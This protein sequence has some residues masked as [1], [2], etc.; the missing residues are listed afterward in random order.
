[1]ATWFTAVAPILPELIRMAK[2]MFTRDRTP[3][4]K[5]PDPA[6]LERQ[7]AELQDAAARNAESVRGLAEEMQRTLEALQAG[8][9]RLEARLRLAQLLA[10]VA[11]TVAGLA[12]AAAAYA[13]AS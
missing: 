11:V 1:L 3:G 5:A 4:G 12:F 6:L 8:A 13:L 10:A 2:P 7:I 9:E